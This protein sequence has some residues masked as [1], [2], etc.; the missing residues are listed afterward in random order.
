[1]K[2]L[3][4]HILDICQN[5]IVAKAS[6]IEIVIKED[7]I[8]DELIIIIKDNGKGMDDNT[9]T[10]VVDPFYTS[11]TTRRVGLGIPMFKAATEATGGSFSIK[12]ALGEGTIVKA[13]FTHSHIDRAPLGN[14]V[15]TMIVLILADINSDFIYRHCINEKEYKLDTRKIKEVLDGV[16]INNMDVISWIKDDI[17]RGL[18]EIDDL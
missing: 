18:N 8:A 14:M 1:M 5:S 7:L 11:R 13:V 9:I 10:K 12:S 6:L 3:S 2:E 15:D 4:M 17:H 16:P